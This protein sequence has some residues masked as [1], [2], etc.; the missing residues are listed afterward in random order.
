[1]ADYQMIEYF[2][3]QQ[4]ASLDDRARYRD[5]VGAGSGVAAGMV[6]DHNQS[7]GILSN[8]FL[9]DFTHPDLRR[10]D[11]AFV[12][13]HSYQHAVPSVQQD[14]AQML[15]LQRGHLI[16]HQRGRVGG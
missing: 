4:L 13:L 8:R 12:N 15:L 2:H 14:H 10:I 1:M 9:E 7:G 5:I 16:L 6:V 11:R 3:V